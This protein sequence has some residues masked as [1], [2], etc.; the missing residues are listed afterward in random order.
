MILEHAVLK[1]KVWCSLAGARSNV[2]F[3]PEVGRLG[4]SSSA[5]GMR[6][7]GGGDVQRQS[8]LP[9]RDTLNPVN[10]EY[11]TFNSNILNISHTRF[12]SE[13]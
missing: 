5:A 11:P 10:I 1:C 9:T 8:S 4:R 3:V 6:Q 7:V 13:H 12:G 2:C